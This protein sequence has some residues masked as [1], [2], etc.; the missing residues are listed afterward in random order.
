[1]SR[2]AIFSDVH[3]NLPALKAVLEDIKK[4]KI[5]QIYC[6]GDL[7]DF[8]PWSNEVIELIRDLHI[9]CLMGNHDERIAFNHPVFP[10]KKHGEEETAARIIAIAHTKAHITAS[11]L[12]YLRGLPSH[13]RLSFKQNESLI[14]LLLVHGS[15]RSNEEYIYEDH[16]ADD[17][18]GMLE[19][20]QSAI[21]VMGHTHQSYVRT[22][23]TDSYKRHMAINCGSV[24]R[25]REGGSHATYLVLNVEKAT[26]NAE[27]IKLQYPVEETVKGI[28]ESD[29]PDFYA[30]FLLT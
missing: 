13:L 30:R 8:A 15:T 24:G 12:E 18:L 27:L 4:K 10:L 1:M 17:L 25:S 5:D 28:L 29:I 22:I 14:Q 2:I 9:P 16:P 20:N 19:E 11:N 23:Q 6:L 21:L 3:G 26:I 7:V